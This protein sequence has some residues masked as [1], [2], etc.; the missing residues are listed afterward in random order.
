M[1]LQ[2]LSPEGGLGLVA[3]LVLAGYHLYLTYEIRKKPLDT[4]IGLN[5]HT[6]KAW[7]Q[8]VMSERRDILAVQSLR[9]WI[10]AASFLASTAILINFGLLNIAFNSSSPGH[11]PLDFVGSQNRTWWMAKLL[12]LVVDFLFAFFS[13]SLAIRSFVHVNFMI[14]VPL[15]EDSLATPEYVGKV[16][17]RGAN[18]YTFGMRGFYFAVPLTLW[19]FGPMWMLVGAF[20]LVVVLYRLDHVKETALF[21]L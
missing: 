19:L 7:V 20:V 18:H 13:F 12:I 16:F 9:N 8:S 21:R 4:V 3:V 15:S 6:R 5:N 11:S 2:D 14:N 10:M 1:A 17:N